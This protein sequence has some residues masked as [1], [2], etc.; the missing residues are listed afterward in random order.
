MIA[1]HPADP[2]LENHVPNIPKPN[3]QCRGIPAI[4]LGKTGHTPVSNR[5]RSLAGSGTPTPARS[6]GRKD[7]MFREKVGWHGA[8]PRSAQIVVKRGMNQLH[9]LTASSC[10]GR[11]GESSAIIDVIDLCAKF[12]QEEYAF[13]IV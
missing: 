13:A 10:S 12:V 5:R 1:S 2:G 3:R 8:P 4:V 7:E 11:P 6:R 9:R